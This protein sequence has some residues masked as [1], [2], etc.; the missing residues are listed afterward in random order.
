MRCRSGLGLG[1]WRN[2]CAS[3][4]HVCMYVLTFLVFTG[5]PS[6]KL[7]L[8]HKHARTE[9]AVYNEASPRRSC[10]F[11]SVTDRKKREARPREHTP[12]HGGV[13]YVLS[14][15]IIVWCEYFHAIL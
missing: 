11:V 9:R 14:D 2:L 7:V 3:S 8:S 10:G 6:E 4:M 5:Q 12:F 1:F 13:R 15:C